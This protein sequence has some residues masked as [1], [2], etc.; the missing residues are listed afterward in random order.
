[1]CEPNQNIFVDGSEYVIQVSAERIRT[2]CTYSMAQNREHC[3]TMPKYSGISTRTTTC[4]KWPA[5]RTSINHRLCIHR[6]Q[7]DVI[8]RSLCVC[9]VRRHIGTRMTENCLHRPWRSIKSRLTAASNHFMVTQTPAPDCSPNGPM[10]SNVH[11][12]IIFMV[13]KMS[14]IIIL[15]QVTC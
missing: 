3:E 4:P 9:P 10:Y 13:C 7:P 15:N 6:I 2:I 12:G 8:M 1:M 11:I 5:G 14:L